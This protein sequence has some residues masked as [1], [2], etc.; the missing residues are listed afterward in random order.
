MIRRMT[1]TSC[2]QYDRTYV[3]TPQLDC[4]SRKLG[5]LIFKSFQEVDN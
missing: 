5:K 3:L 4:S 2:L 1:N